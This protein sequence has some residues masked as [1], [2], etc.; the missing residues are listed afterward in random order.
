MIPLLALALIF[1][2]ETAPTPAQ[3]PKPASP[4]ETASQAKR[5]TSLAL[6]QDYEPPFASD[7]LTLSAVLEEA[8]RTNLDLTLGEVDIKISEASI[9]A[10]LGAYD[11]IFTAGL[12]GQVSESPQRGSQ[13]AF[14][15]GSRSLS[16]NAGL[17]RKF[18]TGGT[19]SLSLTGTRALSDQPV[20][21]FDASAGATTLAQYSVVPTLQLSHPLLRGAGIKVN[22]ADINKAKIATNQAEAA[23]LITAQGLARDIISAYW[24]VLFAHR[25]LAN[26]RRSSKQVQ[27]QLERTN[28]LVAAGRLSPVDAKSV[29]QAIA[30][31]EADVLNAEFA[32]LD[33]SLTLRTLMGQEFA[34][35]DV[36]G[37]LPR[38][39]PVVHTRA[40]NISEEIQQALSANP[41]IR[42][43]ELGLASRRIDEMV[44]ANARLPQLDAAINF[45]PQGRSVDSLPS[46][47]TGASG[48]QG[49]WGEAFRNIFVED[50]GRDGLIADWTLGGSLSLTWD[51]RNRGARGRHQI[52]ELQVQRTEIQ[53]VQTRQQIAAGVIRAAHSL[54]T[55]GKTIEVAQISLDLA[56]DNLVAEEARFQVGRSTNYDVLQR[57]DEVDTAAADALS[58]Q[59][60]Y[61]KALAA[62]QAFTGEILPAYGLG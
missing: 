36:L 51:I 13:V 52:S 14:A 5:P 27:R 54:R 28:A 21:F 9:L 11:L 15:L 59:V 42:Q 58:A 32:L 39:D 47:S 17:S 12:N 2:P 46:P 29:E 40:V 10:S 24:D 25:D 22:R 35:R 44:A 55:A 37:V 49:S 7:E 8:A 23:L 19:I 53:L 41:Q 45:T 61:L 38:T 16:G 31:R 57:L 20:N 33:T 26:K 43:L 56:N 4:A 62:L 18:I 30:A 60:N 3:S 50:V 48:S 6:E 34:E 1:A